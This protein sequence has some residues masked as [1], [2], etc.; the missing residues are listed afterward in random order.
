MPTPMTATVTKFAPRRKHQPVPPEPR[1]PSEHR[2]AF[3]LKR[4]PIMA[5]LEKVIDVEPLDP[6]GKLDAL[7]LAE[8]MFRDNV[9]HRRGSRS[10]P[11]PIIH[12]LEAFGIGALRV[13][14]DSS[15]TGVTPAGASFALLL[16]PAP[17]C[18]INS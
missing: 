4:S 11:W 5:L 3:I 17:T 12:L 8:R 2:V 1:K 18:T 10:N 14:D 7:L 6:V 9:I 13:A 16:P 15:L